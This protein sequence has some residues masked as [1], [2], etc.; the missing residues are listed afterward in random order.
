MSDA[1]ARFGT[2]AWAE[3]FQRGINSSSEYR[4]TGAKWGA[5]WNGNLLFVFEA[6]PELPEPLHLLVRLAGGRCEGCAWVEDARHPEAGFVLRAPF[7]AWREILAGRALAATA[8]LTGKM[9]VEGDTLRLLQ[10][11][12]AH[13]SLIHCAASVPTEFPGTAP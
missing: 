6:D 3:A 12:G 2:P 9:R 8:V 7:A 11:A 4:N 5:G 10:F 1:A 13:R